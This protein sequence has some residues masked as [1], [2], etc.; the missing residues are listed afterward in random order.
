MIVEQFCAAN[1]TLYL[2]GL[3]QVKVEEA[4]ATIAQH[5]FHQI[6]GVCLQFVGFLGAPTHPNLFSL[7][8]D[9]GCIL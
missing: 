2:H 4:C 7:L 9:D 3:V 5:I 6:E 1:S 8:S